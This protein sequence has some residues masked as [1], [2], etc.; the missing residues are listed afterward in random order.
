VLSRGIAVFEDPAGALTA[1]RDA[2]ALQRAAQRELLAGPRLRKRGR[3]DAENDEM[4]Q[5]DFHMFPPILARDLPDVE[6]IHRR[7]CA[8]LTCGLRSEGDSRQ[9]GGPVFNEDAILTAEIDLD[10]IARGKYDFHVVGRY[11]RP[12]VFRLYVNEKPSPPVV[13]D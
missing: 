2:S 8:K 5:Q 13:V 10:E 7:G 3:R 1:D 11:A 9:G 6:S 4:Q 12:D